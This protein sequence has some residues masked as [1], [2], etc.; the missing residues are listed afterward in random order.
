MLHVFIHPFVYLI[1]FVSPVFYSI[2]PFDALLFT[3]FTPFVVMH[4]FIHPFVYFI[5]FVSPVFHS[6][7]H[8]DALT[9]TL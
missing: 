9:F 4:V 5:A 6:F 2:T 7:Y 8:V 3:P 1:A